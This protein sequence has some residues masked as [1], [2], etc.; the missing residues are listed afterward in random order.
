MRKAEQETTI[1]WDREDRI[2]WLGTTHYAQALRWAR[3]GYFVTVLSRTRAGRPRGWEARVPIAAITF[4]RLVDGRLP[5]RPRMRGPVLGENPRSSTGI[6]Q[7]TGRGEGHAMAP[8]ESTPEN[9]HA[10]GAT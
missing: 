4:R 9:P 7:D 10:G 1:R 5:P 2:A 6:P 3:K 8:A